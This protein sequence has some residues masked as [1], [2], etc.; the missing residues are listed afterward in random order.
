M[1]ASSD[2]VAL[3]LFYQQAVDDIGKGKVPCGDKLPELKSFKAQGK[4]KEVCVCVCACVC[5]CER[6]LSL[7]LSL[8][9]S[10]FLDLA[11]SLPGYHTVVFPHCECDARKV[12]HV[13][14]SIS[15]HQ[16]VLQAC[17]T[18]GLEEVCVCVCVCVCVVCGV[19]SLDA[20]PKVL[21]L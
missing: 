8:L 6:C 7:P 19:C 15:H 16:L 21:T 9:P 14:L 3:N 17:S 13:K 1:L 11:R 10:Q 20:E 12:G 5:V 2:P 18:E 4:K